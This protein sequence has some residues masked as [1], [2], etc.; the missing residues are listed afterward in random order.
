MKGLIPFS[1]YCGKNQGFSGGYSKIKDLKALGLTDYCLLATFGHCCF[2]LNEVGNTECVRSLTKNAQCTYQ[3]LLMNKPLPKIR[4][5]EFKLSKCQNG[6]KPQTLQPSLSFPHQ[7]SPWLQGNHL[8]FC[9]SQL[10]AR[11]QRKLRRGWGTWW[12][13]HL[14]LR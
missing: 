7:L 2:I 9:P 13:K 14:P 11:G 3:E 8:P 10:T 1:K 12:Y 6:K 4:E 5:K